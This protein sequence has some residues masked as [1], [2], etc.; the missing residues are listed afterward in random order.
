MPDT[1]EE[2]RDAYDSAVI[3]AAVKVA[4]RLPSYGFECEV[5]FL[6]HCQ[7]FVEL[8]NAVHQRNKFIDGVHNA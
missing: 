1:T 8:V 7:P 3:A 6:I 4:D 5:G 2:Q